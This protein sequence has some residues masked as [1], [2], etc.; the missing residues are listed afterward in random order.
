MYF[1]N[2]RIANVYYYYW[3]QDHMVEKYIYDT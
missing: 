3:K 1:Q 2:E